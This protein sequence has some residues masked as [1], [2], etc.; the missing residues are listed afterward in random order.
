MYD[1]IQDG[2]CYES[3]KTASEVAHHLHSIAEAM[4]ADATRINR[5][6]NAVLDS[7]SSEDG[8]VNLNYEGGYIQ[9]GV[10][11]SEVQA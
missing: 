8:W 7:V 6:A 3:F 10:E 2:D 9:I 1:L 11:V 4:Q 5:M